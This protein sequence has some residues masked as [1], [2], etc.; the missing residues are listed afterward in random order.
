MHIYCIC[1]ITI[2]NHIT[3]NCKYA[4]IYVECWGVDQDDRKRVGWVNSL[5]PRKTPHG[6][7]SKGPGPG[8]VQKR[9]DGVFSV[10]QNWWMHISH[11]IILSNCSCWSEHDPRQCHVWKEAPNRWDPW[12]NTS[13]GLAPGN[14]LSSLGLAPGNRN[15]ATGF[16][17]MSEEPPS[18]KTRQR[19][20]KWLCPAG[21]GCPTASRNLPLQ[22]AKKTAEN[23][24]SGAV[25][26]YSQHSD[27][28]TMIANDRRR[29]EAEGERRHS[30]TFGRGQRSI[31]W[32]TLSL[33]GRVFSWT[34]PQGQ[35]TSV[36]NG[37]MMSLANVAMICS[38][39]DRTGQF[40]SVH[41]S[42]I[43]Y[44]PID[45]LSRSWI[46]H[47]RIFLT[48]WR[49][50]KGGETSRGRLSDIMFIPFLQK[51]TTF[52]VRDSAWTSSKCLLIWHSSLKFQLLNISKGMLEY[53]SLSLEK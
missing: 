6:V 35:V 11:G 5:G 49:D 17:L 38:Y 10:P 16:G 31:E 1:Y 39:M 22:D 23:R 3:P 9:F 51:E 14:R 27:S 32:A 12:G 29:S 24:F 52:T 26:A 40:P 28:E 42:T 47:N 2:I 7:F 41:I 48:E 43:Q 18:Q 34:L 4:A 33:C 15:L 44:M 46:N 13:L 50:V 21:K 20:A 53:P 30:N 45:V 37:W 36:L 8:G 19:G 25:A